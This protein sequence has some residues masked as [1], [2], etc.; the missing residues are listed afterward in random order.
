MRISVP[1]VSL[2]VAVVGIFVLILFWKSSSHTPPQLRI[3]VSET[4]LSAPVIIAA[5]NGYFQ[6]HGVNV[7]LIRVRGGVNCMKM[8][9]SDEVDLATTS[10]SVV[11]FT[12]FERDDFGVLASFAESDNDVKIMTLASK[13]GRLS[14]LESGTAGVVPGS[15]SEFF[16]DAYMTMEGL[17][18]DSVDKKG[19]QPHKLGE[20]LLKEEVDY[21]SVWEPYSYLL[22]RDYPQQVF[23]YETRG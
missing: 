4:P 11:M 19:Y 16:L 13:G 9:L 2:I 21:I 1:I 22:S 8:L 20:A 15:A 18:A 5:S 17:S 10:D 12:R 7:E 23:R 6:K 14:A 3:A